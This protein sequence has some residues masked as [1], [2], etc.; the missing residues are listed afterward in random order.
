[1]AEAEERV[2]SWVSWVEASD[3][4]GNALADALRD[5]VLGEY[6]RQGYSEE[7]IGAYDRSAQWGS[8]TAGIL[9]WMALRG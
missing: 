9:R 8:Q 3:L 4:E 7:V 2:R 1:L 5:W 6:R